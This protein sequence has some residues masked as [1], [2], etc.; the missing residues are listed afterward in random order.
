M[1]EESEDATLN[2]DSA[3]DHDGTDVDWQQR[4]KDTQAAYTKN[5]QALSEAQKVWEDEQALLARVQEKFPHL[6]A[7]EEDD[8]DTSDD[9][10]DDDDEIP[11]HLAEKLKKL[12]ALEKWQQEIDAERGTALF[13]QHLAE[14]LGDREVPA[15]VHDWIRDRTSA[16]GNSRK[17]LKQAVEEYD[18]ITSALTPQSKKKPRAPHVPAGQPGSAVRDFSKMTRDEI[19]A[20]MVERARAMEA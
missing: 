6:L 16:L 2:E 1:L 9:F 14:E 4:Y 13:K 3:E 8:I 12:E 17:A 11:A 20:W 7:E 5:Q 19:D 10:E 15:K 18:E